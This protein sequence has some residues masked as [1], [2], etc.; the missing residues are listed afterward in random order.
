MSQYSC[1]ILFVCPYI[2]VLISA[3]HNGT[4]IST[5]SCFIDPFAKTSTVSFP[6][7]LQEPKGRRHLALCHTVLKASG[8]IGILYLVVMLSQIV[9]YNADKLSEGYTF[10]FRL[11]SSNHCIAN[12]IPKSSAVCIQIC[13]SFLDC[14]FIMRNEESCYVLIK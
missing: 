6:S 8:I 9:H 10:Q 12:K 11:F 5:V 4:C 1:H 3:L 7:P 13:C 2:M 14:Y